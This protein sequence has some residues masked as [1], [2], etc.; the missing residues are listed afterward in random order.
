MSSDTLT[1]EAE[2]V[3]DASSRRLEHRPRR[4]GLLGR[5]NARRERIA[6]MLFVLPAAL[7]FLVILAYPIF[8][9]IR[10]TFFDTN[11]LTGITSFVGLDNVVQ[12]FSDEKLG[13]SIANTV[14]WTVGSLAGQI[15]LG[16]IA[17]LLID[18]PWRGMRYIRQLLLIP[19]VVPVIASALLWTWM[20]DGNYGILSSPLHMLGLPDGSSPLG[21][22]ATS[23]ATVIVINIWRG[24]PFAMLVF[25]AT[26]Q[27]IDQSQYEAA[28]LDG[29]GR[30]RTFTSITLPN[31]V[32]AIAALIALRGVWTLMYFELIWLTTRGGPIGSSETL[33]T[34]LYKVIMGEFRLGYGAAIATVSGL[35]LVGVAI[36]V[37]LVRR[38][39]RIR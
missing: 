21:V 6:G 26:L 1:R 19:Y 28:S 33:A 32:P 5:G 11:L 35:F 3:P 34:Y 23:L 10:S 16:L 4:R 20:L 13:H 12:V 15:L 7:V 39:R 29:A 2:S 27:T 31:L 30:W 37:L 17:A 8:E 14:I 22:E 9:N 24:F 18:S 36:I 38:F 25:W